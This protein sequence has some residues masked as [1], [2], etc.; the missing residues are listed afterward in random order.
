M[1]KKLIDNDNQEQWLYIGAF[2][3][4]SVIDILIAL[5]T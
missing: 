1:F 2:L 3:L 5:F 4:V